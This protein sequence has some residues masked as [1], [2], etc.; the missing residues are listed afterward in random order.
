ME[1]ALTINPI[2]A[3][4]SVIHFPGFREYDLI[5]AHWWVMGIASL[6]SLVVL[7]VQTVRLTR[8]Q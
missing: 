2:A 5:P 3:A 7:F 6:A 8:P 1:K 4:L